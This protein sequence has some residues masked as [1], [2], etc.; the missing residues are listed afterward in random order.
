MAVFST[1]EAGYITHTSTQSIIK[2]IDKGMLKAWR[3]PGSRFRRIEER[4][5]REFMIRNSIPM[6][7]LPASTSPVV[8]VSNDVELCSAAQKLSADGVPIRCL[9]LFD[10]GFSWETDRPRA[11]IIDSNVGEGA[12][13]AILARACCGPQRVPAAVISGLPSLSVDE[14]CEVVSR[15]SVETQL[16][17]MV[18]R[19][20]AG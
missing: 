16:P 10:A 12:T 5:L 6:D 7:R 4:D 9:S 11:V 14:S 18:Q 17:I 2:L 15:D 13:R 20:A 1:G 3:V 19:L 8:L